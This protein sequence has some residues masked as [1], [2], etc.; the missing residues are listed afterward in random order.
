MGAECVPVSKLTV[1]AFECGTRVNTPAD[2][3]GRHVLAVMAQD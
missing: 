1:A 3:R 2:A